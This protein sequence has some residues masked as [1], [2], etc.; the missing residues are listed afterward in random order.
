MVQTAPTSG[1][2]QRY[3]LKRLAHHLD[4]MNPA[5]R[6]ATP[7]CH[8]IGYMEHTILAVINWWFDYKIT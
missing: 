7:G 2:T 6:V 8:S 5:R 4:S 3:G 1:A